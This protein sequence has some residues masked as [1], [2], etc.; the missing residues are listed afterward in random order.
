MKEQGW[1]GGFQEGVEADRLR[2]RSL[3]EDVC[4]KLREKDK[5]CKGPFK[6][7]VTQ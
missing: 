7:Y 1:T 3:V 4:T 6:C 2:W 5:V